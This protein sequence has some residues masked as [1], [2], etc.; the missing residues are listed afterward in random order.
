MPLSVEELIEKAKEQRSRKR[1]EEALV[2][3]LAAVKQDE[4]DSEAWWQVALCRKSL[5]DTRNTIVALRETVELEPEASNAWALLGNLLMS[6]GEKDE[7]REAFEITLDYDD[8]QLT[9]LEGMSS[10]LAEEDDKDQDEEELSILARIERLSSLS[11]FQINRVGILHFRRGSIHEA[12]RC[13]KINISNARHPSQRYNLGLAYNKNSIS[14]DADAIDMWRMTLRDWPDYEPSQKSV[15]S[16]LPRLL[17]LAETARSQVTTLLSEEQWFD[18]YMN[19]F[20]LLNPPKD[21]D[22]N[23]LDA[24]VL[25]K[26]KKTLLQDIDLEDGAVSWMP[27]IVVDKSRAIG[28]YDELNDELKKKWHWQVYRNKPLLNFLTKGSHEHFLVREDGSELETLDLIE[29]DVDFLEWLGKLFAAQFDRVLTKAIN[30]GNTVI[31]ECLLDGRRWV[32]QSIEDDCFRNAQRAVENLIKPLND[33][34]VSAEKKKPTLKSVQEILNH[35][36]LLEIMNL[37]PVFFEKYQNDAVHSI[38]G[39]AIRAFNVHKDIDLSHQIIELAKQFKFRSAAANKTIEEDVKTIE[40]LI[41]EERKHEAKLMK[42]NIRWE[43]TKE[44]V[45]QGGSFVDTNAVS[46]VRWGA[47][48]SGERTSKVCDFL[49]SFS[50]DDG[51]FLTFKWTV[52]QHEMNKSKRIFDDFITATLHYVFPSLLIKVQDRLSRNSSINIGPCRVTNYGVYYEVKGWIFSE[53]HFTPWE[54]ARVKTENGVVHV[55]DAS[56]PKKRV[57]LSLR[58]TDNAP[59]LPLLVNIKNGKDN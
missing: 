2:S 52:D 12:I 3:A 54:R 43:V 55:I 8:E 26:L 51:Q 47:V 30:Q 49:I 18:N 21:I 59:L 48:I 4:Y 34:L 42:G 6:T 31:I 14:Q 23:G 13:W 11:P 56:N 28:L 17:K 25:Q 33:F 58:D 41:R 9:A 27:G 15:S 29:C 38:R 19:P 5:G 57:S 44:G 50:S 24:K 20:Q 40:E 36:H 39:L 35:G 37:L 45:R 46:T 10:I 1:Y 22:F 7:A 16:L 53:E 32:P